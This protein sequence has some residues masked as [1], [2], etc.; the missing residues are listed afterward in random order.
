[1]FAPLWN[2]PMVRWQRVAQ[3][4]HALGVAAAEGANPPAH[5]LI[6]IFGKEPRKRTDT[7]PRA[8]RNVQNRK[9]AMYA[10][11][12]PAY[13]DIGASDDARGFTSDASESSRSA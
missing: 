12:S 7:K 9:E 6:N 3:A 2:R 13:R 5:R 10:T 4:L 1:M 8:R 11:G